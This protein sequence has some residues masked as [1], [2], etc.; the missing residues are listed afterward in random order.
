VISLQGEPSAKAEGVAAESVARLR[1][2][3]GLP[4]GPARYR[5]RPSMRSPMIVRCTSLVPPAID[6]AFDHSH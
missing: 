6:A 1:P 5:G 4:V 2:A 3:D